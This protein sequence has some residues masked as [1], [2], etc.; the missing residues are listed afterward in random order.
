MHSKHL[1]LLLVKAIMKRMQKM[2]SLVSTEKYDV[3]IITVQQGETVE[4]SASY[5]INLSGLSSKQQTLAKGLYRRQLPSL[6]IWIL[7]SLLGPGAVSHWAVQAF[8]LD[9]RT[10]VADFVVSSSLSHVCVCLW[11]LAWRTA[12]A[13]HGWSFLVTFTGGKDRGEGIEMEN[14]TVE[15]EISPS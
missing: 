10:F 7:T 2:V 6:L 11:D 5:L 12:G 15:K 14:C 9:K 3:T 13:T 8:C 1:I 4:R